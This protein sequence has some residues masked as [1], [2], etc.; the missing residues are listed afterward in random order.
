MRQR[1]L[2]A[3]AKSIEEGRSRKEAP[4]GRVQAS[5]GGHRSEQVTR[6][7][8]VRTKLERFIA[9]WLWALFAALSTFRRRDLCMSREG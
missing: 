1:V 7:K 8:V 5:E 9:A 4:R 3:K 2:R 6:A